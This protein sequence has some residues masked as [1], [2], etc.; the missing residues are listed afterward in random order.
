MTLTEFLEQRL[1]EDEAVA[2][3]AGW[4]GGTD[5]SEWEYAAQPWG[6]MR[7][8]TVSTHGNPG[9][10]DHVGITHDSEG[11]SDS[12]D[13]HAGAHIAR[14]DPARVLA[15]CAALRR[16]VE[17]YE[18]LGSPQT[19]GDRMAFPSAREAVGATLRALATVHADHPDFDPAWRLT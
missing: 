11:L 15:Q 16:I 1:A 19:L 7:V 3:S 8:Q 18:H 17:M 6:A 9:Y 10:E 2:R 14:H 13:E 4:H 5:Y 12:V